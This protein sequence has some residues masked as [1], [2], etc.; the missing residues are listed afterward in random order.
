MGPLV[1]SKI[2]VPRRRASWVTRPR[3]QE[4][5]ARA[6]Q[7]P[8]TLVS[9]P[10]GF[11]KTTLLT[12]WVAAAQAGAASFA[13]VSLDERD[14]DPAV[15][16]TYVVAAVRD[17]T[18]S[19]VG[20]TALAVLE[21]P[22]ASV[23]VALTGLVNEL[24]ALGQ[25]LVVVL[26]DFH[27]LTAKGIQEGVEFLLEFLPGHV[28]LV[29]ATR[30]DPALPL[31]RLRA[32]GDLVEL[33][34]SDLRFTVE[35]ATAYF[36]EVTGLSLSA[37][38]VATL[39]KRTE[40]WVAALQLAA[41]SMQDRD[42]VAGFIAGFA[43]DDRY[44]VDYLAEEVLA[45]QPDEVHQFLLSTSILDRLSAPLCDAVTGRADG[46]SML[47]RLER[48][49]LFLSQL[50]DRRRWYR[51]HQLF[52]DVLHA[53][54]LD[55]R[56]QEVAELHRRA[57]EW[58][59]GSRLPSEAIRHAL[60]TRDFDRAADLAEPALPSLLRE[61]REA[62]VR[63]WLRDFPAEVVAV[64]PVLNLG[65][66]GSLMSVNEF[67]GV[68]E[69]L[70]QVERSLAAAAAERVVVDEDQFLTLPGMVELYKAGL[71]L[72]RGDVTGTVTHARLAIDLAAAGDHMCRAAA[73]A[74][75]GLAWWG[76]GE[77]DAA[78]DAYRQGMAGLERAGWLADVLGCSVTVADIRTDQGQLTDALRTYEQVLRLVPEDQLSTLHGVADVLVG[79]SEIHWERN[80]VESARELLRRAES[81]GDAK[82]MP[83]NPFRRRVALSRLRLGSGDHA[84]AVR[85]LDEAER[86]YAADFA[87]DVR[88]VA[89]LRARAWLAQGRLAAARQWARERELQADDELSYVREF[90]HIT[91][92]MVLLAKHQ[93]ERDGG[94]LDDA[95]RLLGRLLVAADGGGRTGRVIEIL[96]LQSL[97]EQARG[98]RVGALASLQRAV[99]LAEPEGYVRTF[100]DRGP[101]MT[102]L[103]RALA[104]SRVA[105]GYLRRLLAAASTLE[106][107]RT[108]APTL[109]DP[110]SARERDVL[111]LL[112]SELDG[113]EIARHLVISVNTL[114]THTKS[115]YAKL[116]VTSRR[117]AV[118]RARELDLT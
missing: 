33:R 103:L 11:G 52:A 27:V 108:G 8:L 70:D 97:A 5:L 47:A 39:E 56:P 19:E 57:S 16:W 26:D 118:L 94:A 109:V 36:D 112:A 29:L 15:F 12:E 81:L 18:S 106:P 45:R 98:D 63:G 13:W 38:D 59:A 110:L 99:V 101:P 83:K 91:L 43:G 95:A 37:S 46:R 55:E 93:E 82:G 17:A 35:E 3:L 42:D 79:M 53:H 78:H 58:Y 25:E 64:R 60:A 104:R 105:P 4:R 68:Q 44:V 111:R 22:Q 30:I 41:L 31:A 92:A 7:A 32:R 102:T 21:S 73:A 9:A 66:V 48:D 113:P 34:A 75:M 6:T 54:L 114:R 10:A 40:G 80:E 51:Y 69:R 62:E 89:A 61:R 115:I 116:G 90:D 67:D 85:L 117:A 2:A 76:E 65:F 14:N 100:V 74:L 96:A 50:D 1:A 49:N 24:Q 84:E 107:G 86:L 77:L 87:P 71:A 88:P 20:A 72:V 28:H 23:E